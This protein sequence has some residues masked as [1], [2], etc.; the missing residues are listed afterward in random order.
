[1]DFFKALIPGTILT[2]VVC[3]IFGSA[4]TKA[5]YLNVT[6]EM[7]QGYGFYW[8]WTLFVA[9]TLLSWAIIAMS[10]K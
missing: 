5:G 1:M 4:R 8:S 2:L 3:G 7:I 9:A 10:P 6:H